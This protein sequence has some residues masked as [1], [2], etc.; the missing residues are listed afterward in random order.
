MKKT[1]TC[2]LF[3]CTYTLFSQSVEPTVYSSNGGSFIIPQGSIAW[4][5]GEP[6][7]ETYTTTTN[8]ATMGFHQP[9]GLLTGLAEETAGNSSILLYP[10][11]VADEL[12]LNFT[13]LKDGSYT[14]VIYDAQGKLIYTG[15]K[16]LST[17]NSQSEIIK[18]TEAA[19]GNYFISI[20]ST[21]NNY[22][23]SIKF[24]KSK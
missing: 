22:S 2:L 3:I 23:K 12:N 21:K 20:V 17:S 6:I 24:I 14:I 15:Q 11:P 10:N 13:G 7:S 18:L 19:N 8:V 5:I 4:T 9:V 1:I 16:E